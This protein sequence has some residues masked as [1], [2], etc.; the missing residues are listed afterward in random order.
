MDY[1]NSEEV[2]EGQLSKI[3]S[4]GLIN[5]TM[6]NLWVDFFRH[7]RDGKYLSANADLD[8]IWTILGGEK[9]MGDSD[10]EKDYFDIEIELSK[11]GQ[12]KDNLEAKG[13]DSPNSKIILENLGKHKVLL[14]RKSLFLRRL[15]NSQGKGSAYQSGDDEE[16]E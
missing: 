14:L 2:I 12:L 15:Q 8:C 1:N 7:Y 4:A 6:N 16:T 11:S 13:F 3:N 5:S 9:D 10:K